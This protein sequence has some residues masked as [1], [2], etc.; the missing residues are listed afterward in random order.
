MKQL[1]ILIDMDDTI[2]GLLKGWVAW[3]NNKYGT[4]VDW[5]S[6][7]SWNVNPYFPNLTTEQLYEPFYLD[8][9]WDWVEPL[10]YAQEMIKRIK[11]DGHKVYIVSASTYETLPAKMD[12]VLFR[13]F[14]YFTFDDVIIASNK[15]MIRGDVM[16]DDGVHNLV[17]GEYVKLL[18]DAPHNREFDEKQYGIR[19]VYDWGEIYDIIIELSKG[20]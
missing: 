12:R 16:I 15:Q 20:D 3:I 19:R 2:E 1:T 14:P 17:G 11:D 8:S 7:R 10:P 4:S 18:M 5:K 6:I 9:F 13:Y